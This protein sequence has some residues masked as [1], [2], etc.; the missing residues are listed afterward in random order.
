MTTTE[1]QWRILQSE[2]Q[3][4]VVQSTDADYDDARRAWNLTV[5]HRPV[6][7]VMATHALDIVKAIQFARKEKLTVSVQ[8]TG[9]GTVRPASGGDLLV[10]TAGM[11]RVQVD[12]AAR[13]AW[14]EAGA[15]WKDVLERTQAVGL[16]PLLGSAPHVGAVGYTLGGGLG[17]LARKYGAAAD[18]VRHF[19]VVTAD[20]KLRRAS[21]TENPDLFW[22]LRGG[23]GNLAVVTGM[24]INLYPVTTV[25]GGSLIYPV[26]MAGEVFPRYRDWISSAPDE[27][28]SSVA[29]MNFPPIPP[30]PEPLRGQ[31]FVMVRGCYCGPVDQ[32][33]ALIQPWR[34]WRSPVIDAF[35][36]MPFSQVATISNDPVDPLPALSTGAWLRALSDDAIAT[37]LGYA[38]PG[39]NPSPLLVVEVR[40]IAGT[41]ATASS[42]LS[43][44]SSQGWEL[45][46]Q[47]VGITPTPEAYNHVARL[48]GQVKAELGPAL[49]GAIYMNL[50]EGDESRRRVKDGFTPQAYRRL[51]ALKSTFDPDNLLHSGFNLSPAGI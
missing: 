24:E 30:V 8:S 20:G 41:V 18:S 44:Y 23:S 27:L 13:T 42:P 26:E 48:T 34:D 19:E 45:L 12:A 22:G 29:V 9:H 6:G 1:T 14:I 49:S 39:D 32:G 16:A 37:L 43:A 33:E 36:A 3:G 50:V 10:N 47:L 35:K 51:L 31:S 21:E 17:W 5:N 2:I 40:H 4:K 28:T 25:Y 38:I 46:L 7:V 11:V 15:K